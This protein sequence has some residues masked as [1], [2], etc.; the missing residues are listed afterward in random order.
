MHTTV[1]LGSVWTL[2]ATGLSLPNMVLRCVLH[3]NNVVNSS[4]IRVKIPYIAYQRFV[5][6][7]EIFQAAVLTV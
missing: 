4:P 6:L 7:Y 3:E 5:V 2:C 1:A